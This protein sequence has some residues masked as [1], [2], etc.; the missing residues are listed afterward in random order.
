MNQA[1][2]KKRQKPNENQ[3]AKFNPDPEEVLL[4]D[5]RI[6]NCQLKFEHKTVWQA[7][8][9]ANSV[10]NR[11]VNA[12]EVVEALTE[13]EKNH[14]QK[15][16]AKNLEAAVTVILELLSKRELV[17]IQNN[18]KRRYFG[19]HRILNAATS[20][21]P[22]PFVSRRRYTLKLVHEAVEFYKR[23]VRAADI[24]E[25]VE[26][27]NKFLVF[28]KKLIVRDLIN[29]SET[30]ELK[31]ANGV[32]GDGGGRNLY[33]PAGFDSKDYSYDQ[34]LTWLDCVAKAFNDI[35]NEH[36]AYAKAG[37]K[38]TTAVTTAEIREC[39]EAST[40]PHPRLKHPK[41]V[42]NAMKQ[43]SETVSPLIKRVKIQAT[44]AVLWI[45]AEA[46][47]SEISLFG[48]IGDNS[49]KLRIAVKRAESKLQRPV[50]VA[51]I[52]NEIQADVY[53]VPDGGQS[54]G[55]LLTEASRSKIAGP[56][57]AR[58]ERINTII[59]RIGT[60]NGRTYYVS[61]N[62]NFEE[63]SSF[64]KYL[65][66]KTGWQRFS[67]VENIQAIERC[68]LISVK[69]GRMLLLRNE[70]KRSHQ[71]LLNLIGKAIS[72]AQNEVKNL[73]LEMK[74]IAEGAD[75]W[76]SQN[77]NSGLPGEVET[78]IPGLTAEKLLK[79]YRPLYPAA[80]N[81]KNANRI[82]T[83][84]K[85]Q[86]R[87]IPNVKFVDRFKRKG[88]EASEWLFD[89]ADA[90]IYAGIKWGGKECRYQALT[91]KSELG[92]LRDDRFVLP[93]LKS[94]HPETK[95]TAISCL[96]FLQ[97]EEAK[98]HLPCTLE[99]NTIHRVCHSAVWATAFVKNKQSL[100]SIL[101]RGIFENDN[102]LS[103]FVKIVTS[104]SDEKL[105]LL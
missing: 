24:I 98:N 18:G 28:E 84:C 75:E 81:I 86:I 80:A 37:D 62:Q 4:L 68:K 35:W 102:K 8:E 56:K 52:K 22:E 87:R 21:M 50:T 36:T 10:F 13:S 26:K 5:G 89:R 39:L 73:A 64:V 30:G 46:A 60:A 90:L 16:Y 42:T 77:P 48:R 83:L 44:G 76:L 47:E 51:D 103:Q 9:A 6:I 7:L 71:E 53:L 69:I 27:Q 85:T 67:A 92:L 97:T 33:L 40:F 93:E 95:I 101:Q 34:S 31:I 104:S 19:S 58:R 25:F 32:R 23:S 82:I 65:N 105:W 78:N 94:N 20:Q 1:K 74:K 59:Q 17:F 41:S 70:A 14:L 63:A 11:V 2:R 38:L 43:L 15:T 91:A 3:S 66:L 88:I 79:I 45:P 12:N 29:L 49:N 57:G 54:L 100:S 72:S 96:A 99:N 61:E 55:K